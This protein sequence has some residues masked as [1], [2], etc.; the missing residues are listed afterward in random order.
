MEQQVK[1]QGEGGRANRH[2]FSLFG[3]E[4]SAGKRNSSGHTGAD[5]PCI[6]GAQRGAEARS[7]SF[8]ESVVTVSERVVAVISLNL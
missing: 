8:V 2:A 6:S 4:V 7:A 3:R 1:E 5:A